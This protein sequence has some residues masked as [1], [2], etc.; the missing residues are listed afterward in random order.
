MSRMLVL[1]MFARDL[2]R[3]R[4]GSSTKLAEHL[5]ASFDTRGA[6]VALLL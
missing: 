2:L 5:F 1:R 3:M 6:A 4:W